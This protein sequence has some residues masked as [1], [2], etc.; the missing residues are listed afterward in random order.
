MKY[1]IHAL[2]IALLFPACNRLS[3]K[4]V[5]AGYIDSLINNRTVALQTKNNESD[6]LFWKNRIDPDRPGQVNEA[7][8][9]SALVTRFREFGDINDV[10][11][12]ES[13]LRSINKTYNSTLASPFIALTSS[14]LLQHRF[15]EADTLLQKAKN[16]GIN[17]FTSCTLSFDINFELGRYSIAEYYLKQLKGW[18]DYSY[19]FRLSKYD[20]VNGEIDSAIKDMLHAA[21]LAKESAYLRGIA[22]S[23]AGDL[24]IHAGDLRKAVELYKQCIGLNPADFH[25]ITR[26]GWVALVHDRNDTLSERIFKFVQAKNKLPDPLFKLYQMAQSRGDKMLEKRYANEFVAKATDTRYGKMYTKYLIEIYTGIL[27]E[28]AKA[29]GLAREELNNRAT[30]QTYAWYAYSLFENNKKED[31]YKVFQQHISGGAL[32]GLELY[33]MG[34]MME[35]LGKGYNAREFFKAA[36]KNKYDLSPDMAE[37]LKKSLKE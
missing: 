4:I 35:G 5:E 7:K 8:Y 14:A 27:D 24:Y 3:P 12:A 21:S 9:A 11:E 28:P 34:K 17:G 29:E 2:L 20:H 13:V 36:D 26:L 16:I 19:Y 32:E 37:N 15:M 6:L 25:S 30:P 22:L 33:Y 31:A 1:Q 18:N 10:K 23:N